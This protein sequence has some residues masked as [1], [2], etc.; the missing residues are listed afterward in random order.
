MTKNLLKLTFNLI[1]FDI[2][3]HSAGQDLSH[4]LG[5]FLL[6]LDICV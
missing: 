6:A 5:R 3:M 2:T 4:W 1:I